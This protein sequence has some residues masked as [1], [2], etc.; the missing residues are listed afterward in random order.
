MRLRHR[1]RWLLLMRTA[2]KA[3]QSRRPHAPSVHMIS[4]P[5][6]ARPDDRIFTPRYIA[7][8]L[9]AALAL[10]ALNQHADGADQYACHGAVAK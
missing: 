7:L 4:Y 8:L 2:D 3:L 9:V 1:V 6:P 10:V 5:V